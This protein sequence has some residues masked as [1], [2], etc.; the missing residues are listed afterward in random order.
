MIEEASLGTFTAK[1]KS[2]LELGVPPL[3]RE[4]S[5]EKHE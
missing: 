3:G 5:S 2:A 4:D 1:V